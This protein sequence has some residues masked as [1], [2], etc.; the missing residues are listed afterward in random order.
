[1]HPTTPNSLR[2]G[3]YL[4]GAPPAVTLKDM[5]W[6]AV[7]CTHHGDYTV[8]E[9]EAIKEEQRFSVYFLSYFSDAY[10]TKLHPSLGCFEKRF[11]YCRAGLSGSHMSSIKRLS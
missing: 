5:S 2:Q 9:E 6:Q 10:M 4:N 7:S 3:L 1:M 8:S 11:M